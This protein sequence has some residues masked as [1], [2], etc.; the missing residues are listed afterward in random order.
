[1]MIEEFVIH[2]AVFVHTIGEAN[3]KIATGGVETQIGTTPTDDMLHGLLATIFAK[4][5]FGYKLLPSELSIPHD[6]TKNV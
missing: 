4:N 3:E 5:E 1:M 2:V 6:E